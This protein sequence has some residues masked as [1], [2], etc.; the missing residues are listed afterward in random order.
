MGVSFTFIAGDDDFLVDRAGK[1]CFE[2]W[3]KE[4]DDPMSA[5]LVEGMAQKVDDVEQA[6][7]RFQ[8]AVQTMALFGGRKAVWLRGVNFLAD[9][10]TGQ[11]EGT[12]QQ[13]ERLQSILEKCDP[14]AVSI[15]IT[16]TPVDRRRR[17]FK[18]FQT[19]GDARDIKSGGDPGAL[20]DLVRAE[21]ERLKVKMSPAA[22]IM[23]I[24]KVNGNTRLVLG[25]IA[26][27]ATY[28]GDEGGVIDES[29]VRDLVPQFGEGDFFEYTEAF[30]QYDLPWALDALKR[31]F[32]V[33]KEARPL[34]AT[35]QGRNRLLIQLRVLM[36]GGEIRLG[37]RGIAKNEFE[38]AAARYARHFGG[39][40]KSNL[41][42]FTQ[43]LWY[44]G[45]KLAPSAKKLTL[46]RLIDF[47]IAFLAAFEGLIEHPNDQ[48]NV[49]RELTLR[50]LAG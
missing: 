40:E 49:M 7:T 18:W 33:H 2:V 22:E 4:L 28:I 25:E 30:F 47:Q 13:V 11:A 42:L 37:A 41:N 45:N 20:A 19:H 23:L 34:I 46:R 50:C 17:E 29:L 5:E 12:K 39:K 10:K 26:K 15:V 27:L 48:E 35:L 16:A 43:N 9:S 24:E 44:L 21:T 6:V 3:S 38:Q 1:A 36:D 32:F 31:Y 14:E 8:D